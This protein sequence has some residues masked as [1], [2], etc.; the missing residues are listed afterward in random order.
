MILALLACDA[1]LED[2]AAE[3]RIWQSVSAGEAHTCALDA[4]LSLIHI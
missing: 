2:T 4:A 3:A 1:P